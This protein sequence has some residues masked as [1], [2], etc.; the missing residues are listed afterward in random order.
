MGIPQEALAAIYTASDVLLAASMAEGFGLTPLEAQAT[1]TP[2]IVTDFSAQ[3]ELVGDG[4]VVPGQPYYN[5]PQKSWWMT[6][7][8]GAIEEALEAAYA[9]GRYRSDKAIAF[10]EDYRADKVYAE[11][12][13]PALKVLAP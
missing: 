5:A 6:P 10:A 12:W 1:G 11:H 7:S 4:W 9:K 8:I 2:V 3:P 13:R